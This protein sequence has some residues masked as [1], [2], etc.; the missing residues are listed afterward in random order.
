M[1]SNQRSVPSTN[2]SGT[3]FGVTKSNSIKGTLSWRIVRFKDLSKRNG[4]YVESPEFSVGDY[5]WSL[6]LYPAGSKDEAKNHISIFLSCLNIDQEVPI[7][8]FITFVSNANQFQDKTLG[9]IKKTFG[10]DE[11]DWGWSK[12]LDHAHLAAYFLHDNESTL[13]VKC[14]VEVFTEWKTS[15][16]NVNHEEFPMRVPVPETSILSDFERHLWKDA[17]FSDVKFVVGNDGGEQEF[18]GHKGILSARSPVFSRM[19]AASMREGREGVVRVVDIEP[20]IFQ[21]MLR[22]VYCDKC[23]E[24]IMQE[25][26]EELLAVADKYDIMRLKLMCENVLLQ[27]VNVQNAIMCLTSADTYHATA[28]KSRILDFVT[29]HFFEIIAFEGFK[30]WSLQNPLL[31]AEI[32]ESVSA[33]AGTKGLIEPIR[34]KKVNLHKKRRLHYQT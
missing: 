15:I 14:E 23:D 1:E 6:F 28:L 32:H 17:A 27:R 31:V 20:T 34:S 4:E 25:R 22:Y 26:T 5:R 3:V 2:D 18:K 8:F 30:E 29:L 24:K 13:Y 11:L 16:D 19:F 10:E 12:A 9:P 7:N 21:E 33:K